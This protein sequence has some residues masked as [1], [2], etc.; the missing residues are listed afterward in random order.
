M[1]WKL[2]RVC[3]LTGD[4][5]AVMLIKEPLGIADW[6]YTAMCFPAS[7]KAVTAEEGP[8]LLHTRSLSVDG[9]AATQDLIYV[10]F[11]EVLYW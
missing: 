5:S 1:V 6:K 4:I 7:A 11:F 10:T 9:K 2:L 3:D 8:F